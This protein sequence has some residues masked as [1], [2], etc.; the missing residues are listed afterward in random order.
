MWTSCKTWASGTGDTIEEEQLGKL[1][2]R[3]GGNECARPAT[4]TTTYSSA[5]V[6]VVERVPADAHDHGV[7]FVVHVGCRGREGRTIAARGV[8]D[9][10]V[11]VVDTSAEGGGVRCDGRVGQVGCCS[12]THNEPV[13]YLDEDSARRK[14]DHAI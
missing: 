14:G 7:H 13:S 4:S 2:I 11:A 1:V 12:V 8:E 3:A 10:S 9:A 6:V 5:G